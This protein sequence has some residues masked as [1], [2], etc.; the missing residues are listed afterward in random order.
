VVH[1]YRKFK[2]N[3]S[4]PFTPRV[5]LF[6]AK[7]APGYFMAK[8]IIKLINSVA[9]VVNNDPEVGD[10]LKVLFLANYRV[11]LAEK[12]IPAADLSEQISTAGLE[13][14][15]TGNMK[16]SL[17]G[18]ITIGTWDGANVE[19]AEEVGEENC[20]LFG[21]K[22]DE[23]LELQKRGYNPRDYI[24]ANADLKAVLD[25][26]RNGF[27]SPEKP[28]LFE[29]I[30]H[31]LEGKDTYLLAADFA[32]YC[33]AQ[34]EASVVYRNEKEW[35]KRS[36]LN[37]ARMGKFSSDRTIGEYAKDIWNVQSVGRKAG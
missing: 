6:G 2:E 5:I 29:P 11:S 18:A 14:S 16:L 12:I 31:S 21:L 28:D 15:G 9:T 17:N 20:F 34:E 1:L 4:A 25:L 26:I 8:L 23:V 10:K 19:I 36:I 3:P 30:L 32:D 22:S 7:A 35:T 37:T 24:A 13:A 33:R 27:F